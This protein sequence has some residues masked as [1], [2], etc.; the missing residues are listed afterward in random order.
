MKTIVHLLFLSATVSG[1][2]ENP[3]QKVIQLLSELE[4]KILKQGEIEETAY[5]EFVDFCQNGAREKQFEIKTATAKKEDL[6]ATIGKATSTIEE[7]TA[8][9]SDLASAISTNEA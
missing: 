2:R 6:E 5:K 7:E 8:K 3:V 1:V 9:I 4:A